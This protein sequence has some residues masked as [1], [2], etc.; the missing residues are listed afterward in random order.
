M[1]KPKWDSVVGEDTGE[2]FEGPTRCPGQPMMGEEEAVG[3]AV[4]RMTMV[5]PPLV[6]PRMLGWMESIRAELGYAI[7]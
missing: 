5:S 4:R 6:S 1:S 7:D 3:T 2:P